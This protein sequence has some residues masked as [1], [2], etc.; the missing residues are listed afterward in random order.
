MATK[1]P[2]KIVNTRERSWA[3]EDGTWTRKPLPMYLDARGTA[4]FVFPVPVYIVEALG[5]PNPAIS[6]PTAEGAQNAWDALV[7]RYVEHCKTAVAKPVLM[8][9]IQ[10]R[11]RDDGGRLHAEGSPFGHESDERFVSLGY[12]RAFNVNGHI[13][14]A[15]RRKIPGTIFCTPTHPND[16]E[17]AVPG[18]RNPYPKGV[19]LPWTPELEAQLVAIQ[20]TIDRAALA[21]DGILKSKDVGAALLGLGQGL[22]TGPTP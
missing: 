12:V 7:V 6:A 22:L 14:H 10:Y 19:E 20:A 13:H 11:G 16:I 1:S 5:L 15:A 18:S 17:D 2:L 9:E 4:S 3:N 8:V 21:L